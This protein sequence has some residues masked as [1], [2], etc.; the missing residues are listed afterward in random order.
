MKIGDVSDQLG[1]PA[2]TI[3]YYEKVG[4]IERQYRQSGR[5]VFDDRAVLVLQFVQLAQAAGF[6]IDETKSLLNAYA[7]DP[8]P[9]GMWKPFAE[10]KREAIRAQIKELKRMDQVL[11]ELLKCEC[12][13]LE[14]CVE[15]A[16]DTQPSAKLS[17]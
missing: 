15:K 2:S 16:C 13:T 6:T 9:N 7:K 5:R 4:L 10:V 12:E 11:S 8:S 3:R 17:R 1:I 14:A